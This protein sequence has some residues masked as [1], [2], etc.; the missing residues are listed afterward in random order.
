[1]SGL[2][3]AL[4]DF[5]TAML[6]K[7]MLRAPRQGDRS[8]HIDGNLDRMNPE[9]VGEH[10]RAE[11]LERSLA[12]TPGERAAEDVDVANM[13]FLDWYTSRRLERDQTKGD[14]QEGSP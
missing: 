14:P 6:A 2:E 7:F 5:H 8:V 11:Q 4:D 1:M 9:H 10:Y 3:R 13:A 12:R